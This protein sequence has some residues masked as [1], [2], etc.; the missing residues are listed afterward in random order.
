MNDFFHPAP[1][2]GLTYEQVQAKKKNGRQNNPP[3]TINKSTG[4]ILKDNICS[5]FSIC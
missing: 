4:R 3:E 1:E 2:A 5:T